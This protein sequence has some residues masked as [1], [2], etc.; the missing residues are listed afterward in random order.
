MKEATTI[1]HAVPSEYLGPIL[2]RKA[3]GPRPEEAADPSC[4]EVERDRIRRADLNDEIARA[5]FGS[6]VL[7]YLGLLAPARD[8]PQ[9]VSLPGWLARRLRFARS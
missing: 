4:D 3:R 1:H 7:D 6:G 2:L 8:V 5:S 9:D